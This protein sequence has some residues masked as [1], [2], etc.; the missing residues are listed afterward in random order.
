MADIHLCVRAFALSLRSTQTAA[1]RFGCSNIRGN[2]NR[3]GEGGHKLDVRMPGR[4]WTGHP[5]R[6][7]RSLSLDGRSWHAQ[8]PVRRRAC[9]FGECRGRLGVERP[10][11]PRGQ[12]SQIQLER[13][14]LRSTVGI[15]RTTVLWEARKTHPENCLLWLGNGKNSHECVVPFGARTFPL[16]SLS[17]L[18]VSPPPDLR[19]ELH[20][21]TAGH[22]SILRT[23][24]AKPVLHL[25]IFPREVRGMLMATRIELRSN[26]REVRTVRK[27]LSKTAH[28]IRQLLY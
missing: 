11:L 18:I 23:C 12:E 25:P 26:R 3:L 7:W 10:S 28:L 16:S 1:G 24:Y 17:P 5:R 19:H 2:V 9:G 4:A 20:Q 13:S 22:A 8:Q 6:L 15:R 14:Y 27:K 21:Q